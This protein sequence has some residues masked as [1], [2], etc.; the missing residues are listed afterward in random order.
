MLPTNSDLRVTETSWKK[1]QSLMPSRIDL[2]RVALIRDRDRDWLA[3]RRNVEELIPQL[4]L[5]GEGMEEY[6]AW[7]HPYCGNGLRIWQYPV[8]FAPYLCDLAALGIRSYLEIGIRHGGTFVATAEYLD[9]FA[10]LERAVGI[11]ILPCPGFDD[12]RA[13]NPRAEFVRVDT[14]SEAWPRLMER[15]GAIDLVL[16]DA[17]HDETQCRREFQSVSRQARAIAIHDVV[18]SEFDG[19]RKV[20]GEIKSSGQWECREYVDQYDLPQS[21]MGIGLAIRREQ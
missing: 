15:L 6:P 18:H 16:I 19:V 21:Y 4:G 17:F 2:D 14:Q 7:L 8:Q 12:Y 11:D 13:M 20:W 10:P 9:R 5:N 3:D 1:L